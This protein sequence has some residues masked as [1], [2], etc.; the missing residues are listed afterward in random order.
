MKNQF[1]NVYHVIVKRLKCIDIK[2]MRKII[3][4]TRDIQIGKNKIDISSYIVCRKGKNDNYKELQNLL[5][6]V[7]NKG[8]I[9]AMLDLIMVN[10]L[11]IFRKLKE[12]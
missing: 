8:N 4:N 10:Q 12:K 1:K 5:I 3:K 2:R 7:A 11:V 6:K 9:P